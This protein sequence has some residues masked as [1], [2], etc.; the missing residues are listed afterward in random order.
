MKR[1]DALKGLAAMSAA[2]TLAAGTMG[3][4][5]NAR[6]AAA[7]QMVTVAKIIGI[8]WFNLLSDGITEGGKKFNID[9][10]MTGPAHVDP[11]AQ[12]SM[13]EDLIAKRVNVIGLVPLDVKVMGPVLQRAQDAG[14]I[15]ITQEG[16]NQDNRT[17]DVEMIDSTAFGETQMKALA[18][19][20]GERGQYII[21]VGTLTTPLHNKWADAAIA[22][23]KAHYPNMSLA[24]SRFPGSDE[25]D[26]AEQVMR[27]TLQ[28]YPDV[29][30]VIG[31][32]SNGAIGAGN[33]IRQR[34]LQR[35][36]S[37]LGT[38]IPSQVK[39][40]LLDGSVR[41]CFVWSP[42]DA[43]YAMVAVASLAL[44]KA[45]FTDGMDIPGL[46]RAHVDVP[47]RLI[48]VDRTLAINKDTVDKL[49]AQGL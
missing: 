15:V 10:T 37:I 6:A 48:S 41:E 2:G 26:S 30:G 42:K 25:V 8:P 44:Q 1:R 43:G 12:V 23:Q 24:T 31:F 45:S 28:A 32:G 19:N 7:G 39:P 21:M 27:N 3:W 17:W 47:G 34:H 38:A 49:I 4:P 14:I 18:K 13:V 22:Y 40:L 16:P 36:I 46:G 33:V 35:K 29:R 9:A 11:A 20:M 5:G